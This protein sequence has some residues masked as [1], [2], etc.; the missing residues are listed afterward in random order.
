MLLSIIFNRTKLKAGMKY[1]LQFF[2]DDIDISVYLYNF[3]QNDYDLETDTITDDVSDNIIVTQ[4]SL[5]GEFY[6]T[7]EFAKGIKM[8]VSTKEDVIAAYGEPDFESQEGSRIWYCG[9]HHDKDTC[10]DDYNLYHYDDHK[11]E[12][13]YFIEFCFTSDDESQT[14]VITYAV[15][16]NGKD[17]ANDFYEKYPDQIP[18]EK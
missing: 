9:E 15:M 11:R 8:H 16:S 12:C 4:M 14:P 3:T 17:V 13:E 1:Y 2:A 10:V 5:C 18:T 7:V 6:D